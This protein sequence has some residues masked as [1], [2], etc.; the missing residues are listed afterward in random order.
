MITRALA[1]KASV[2][3]R[4]D[5]CGMGWNTLALCV[6]YNVILFFIGFINGIIKDTTVHTH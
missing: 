5:G 2:W 1:K 6:G 3:K 4:R